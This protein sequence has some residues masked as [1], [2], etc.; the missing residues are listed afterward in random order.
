MADKILGHNPLEVELDSIW[1]VPKKIPRI[2][3]MNQDQFA[4]SVA[5][6]KGSS[7]YGSGESGDEWTPNDNN[8]DG[9][10][11][12]ENAGD[13][14]IPLFSDDY[15]EVEEKENVG[16]EMV[17]LVGFKL[18]SELYGINIM[19]VQEIIR[20]LD[21]TRIPR[22]LDFVKGVLNLRGKVVPVISLRER[23]NFP[24]E[25]IDHEKV[26]IVLVNTMVG[27]A[28]FE[29]DEV[30]EVFS[31]KKSIISP[32]PPSSTKLDSEYIVG[33]GRLGETLLVILNLDTL[34][35]NTNMTVDT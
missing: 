24:E 18:G 33:V 10:M 6:P 34:V 1:K 20:N 16:V 22:S 7:P 35:E 26:R 3:E 5:A 23:F 25:E 31:I 13:D 19:N 30:T 11:Y 9:G 28:G 15:S 14:D 27:L 4:Q 17:Q 29:V 8:S 21:I 32:P 2:Q 12:E